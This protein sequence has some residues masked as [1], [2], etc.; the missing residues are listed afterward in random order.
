MQ[1]NHD[2]IIRAPLVSLLARALLSASVEPRQTLK[3]QL[4]SGGEL[5]RITSHLYKLRAKKNRSPPLSA[6]PYSFVT[7]ITSELIL[8]CSPPYSH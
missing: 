4:E 6:A 3:M 1:G 5:T 2:V 7:E 8:N